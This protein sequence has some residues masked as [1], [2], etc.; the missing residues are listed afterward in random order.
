MD[1]LIDSRLD[2]SDA[3][4]QSQV[5][6]AL[7]Q[8]DL[9]CAAF[10]C[11]TKT[12][13]R[14]IPRIFPSG[15]KAPGPLRTE[16]EPLGCKTLKGADAERVRLD[17]LACEFASKALNRAAE[18]G[19]AGIAENPLR[20]LHWHL[21]DEVERSAS[22]LWSD[23]RYDAC[24]LH[25]ARCKAQNLR[26]TANL[27]EISSWPDVV[28][29]HIHSA[30]EWKP[31]EVKKGT[32]VVTHYPSK[33]EA[34]YTAALC[35]AI[36]V[37]CSM[38][39][40][41]VGRAKLAVGRMPTFEPAGDRRAWLHLPPEATREWAMVPMAVL[42][43]V[44]SPALSAEC[45]NP[46]RDAE[47]CLE[48]HVSSGKRKYFLPPGHVYVGSGHHSHRLA[49]SEWHNPYLPGRDG[50]A[51]ECVILYSQ[52]LRESPLYDRLQEL[53]GKT[54][55]CDCPMSGPC[56]RDVLAAEIWV[57]RRRPRSVVRAAK[58]GTY[59]KGLLLAGAMARG[60]C[61]PQQLTL[62][63]PQEHVIQAMQRLVPD[64]MLDSY[65]AFPMMED[66]LN[67][68]PFNTYLE[69]RREKDLD[70]DGP[71]GPVDTSGQLRFAARAA[72]DNSWVHM[73]IRHPCRQWLPMDS[74][75][76][77]IFRQLEQLVRL[78]PCHTSHSW[79]MTCTLLL[80]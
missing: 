20:S 76:M 64:G 73:P 2:F 36:A 65:Q 34:T 4:F 63:F 10:D 69:Y 5:D 19:A 40:V 43:N 72:D 67:S 77:T 44:Q 46:R 17:N 66:L 56:H 51:E 53:A 29:Q 38:W 50:A 59:L 15:R 24:C 42:L 3:A 8:V 80:T 35:Y 54:L 12:R 14:E 61:L 55:V 47:S 49:R 27:E 74:P 21:P 7:E 9:V 70:L 11:S 39:A 75:R 32:R 60:V 79:M 45:I 62:D 33:E 6:P 22:P 1:Y 30:T 57:Q 37:S 41:R 31:V 28:C 71:F 25:G 23:K 58:G 13:I 78:T 18:R 52:H 48:F 16:S 68:F 26:F